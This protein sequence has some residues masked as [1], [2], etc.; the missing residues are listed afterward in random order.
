LIVVI[1][2]SYYNQLPK[3][4]LASHGTQDA[5]LCALPH[6][7]PSQYL[8]I[9]RQSSAVPGHKCAYQPYV[10]SRMVTS[11]A[12]GLTF[13]HI[14]TVVSCMARVTF[15]DHPMMDVRTLHIRTLRLLT[16][17]AQFAFVVDIALDRSIKE[18]FAVTSP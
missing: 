4:T 16:C 3:A 12:S 2:T 10:P 17:S 6:L 9:F 11:I 15:K 8:A 13:Y 7:D 1:P 5:I 14:L 18:R